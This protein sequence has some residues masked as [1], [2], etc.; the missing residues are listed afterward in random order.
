M[1][2]NQ[3]IEA[4]EPTILE[5]EQFRKK[6]L[7]LKQLE[8]AFY[9]IG[10]ILFLLILLTWG[11]Y[12]FLLTGG[13]FTV[14]VILLILRLSVIGTPK[15]DYQAKYN[16][17]VTKAL[18]RKLDPAIKYASNN[19]KYQTGIW[20]SGLLGTSNFAGNNAVVLDGKTKNGYAFQLMEA[21]L[22]GQ[23]MLAGR[24]SQAT[25]KGMIV[26]IEGAHYL[27]EHSIIKA[28]KAWT[29][30]SMSMHSKTGEEVKF[31]LFSTKHKSASFNE[32][33]V[34]YTKKRKEVEALLT[35]E[36]LQK[37]EALMQAQK[38]PVDIVLQEKKLF[39]LLSGINH[40]EVDLHQ[41]LARTNAV[42]RS[43][44]KIKSALD[45]VEEFSA[46]IGGE[47]GRMKIMLKEDIKP[48]DNAT[49]SA[50]DHFIED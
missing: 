8:Y 17:K 22:I 21:S 30:T 25:Y 10:T 50:Y 48:L 45:L 5:V 11:A 40:F 44:D 14:F 15:K 2:S 34:V 4:L 41:S 16:E 9:G 26:V 36:A 29:E 3:L 24:S 31:T 32:K 37:M 28:K 7:R 20:N 23:E 12:G 18:I 27:G 1:D 46:L 38:V 49:D 33:Y 39:L 47:K 6:Q 19:Y 43:C 35:T 42:N 13:L